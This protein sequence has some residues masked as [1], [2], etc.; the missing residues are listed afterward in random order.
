LE[1]ND[2]HALPR[3]HLHR[4]A[5]VTVIAAVLAIVLTLALAAGL[6]DL[7]TT[8]TSFTAHRTP[9]ATAPSVTSRG[10]SLN[11]FGRLLSAPVSTPWTTLQ[12]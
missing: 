6:N 3:L 7:A 5:T 9:V 4:A 12:P 11:P 2:M 8:P 10:W 1:V